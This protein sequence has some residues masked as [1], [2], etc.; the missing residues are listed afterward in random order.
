MKLVPS[1]NYCSIIELYIS[2][3]YMDAYIMYIY[4]DR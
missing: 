4:I 1:L 2:H 3:T